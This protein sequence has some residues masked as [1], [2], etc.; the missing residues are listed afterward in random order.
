ETEG[1][2]KKY[3]PGGMMSHGPALHRFRPARPL[4][5]KRTAHV[6]KNQST[7]S[8]RSKVHLTYHFASA[9]LIGLSFC[10]H[11]GCRIKQRA[12]RDGPWRRP[13]QNKNLRAVFCDAMTSSSSHQET[14]D[15]GKTMEGR[16]EHVSTIPNRNPH[17]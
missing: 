11:S 16:H 2:G 15:G 17:Q 3:R 6:C 8:A 9:S 10:G 7:L 14:T 13:F 4:N 1:K 12:L 5:P